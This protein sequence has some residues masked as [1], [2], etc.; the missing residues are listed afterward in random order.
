MAKK[1]LVKVGRMAQNQADG[2]PRYRKDHNDRLERRVYHDT[3][4]AV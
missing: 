1:Y 2:G 3:V 4:N